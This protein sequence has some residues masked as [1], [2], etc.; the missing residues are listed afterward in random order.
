MRAAASA[1]LILVAAC[2]APPPPGSSRIGPDSS[3]HD[4]SV[5]ANGIA[6]SWTEGRFPNKT[7]F[8]VRLDADGPERRARFPNLSLSGP[9][10]LA[11]DGKTA[12]AGAAAIASSL[13]PRANPVPDTLLWIQAETGRLL[14]KRTL[15]ADS[16]LL[17]VHGPRWAPGPLALWRTGRTVGWASFSASTPLLGQSSGRFDPAVPA[18]VR[19]DAPLAAL[20]ALGRP[21]LVVLDLRA[22]TELRRFPVDLKARPLAWTDDGRLL[23]SGWSIAENAYRLELLD[24]RDGSRRPLASLQGEAESAAVRGTNALVIALD[25]DRRA[26]S[27]RN[28]M[29]SRRLIS[30]DL[31]AERLVWSENWTSRPGRLLGFDPDGRVLFEVTDSDQPALW[32]LPAERAALAAAV[33]ALDGSKAVGS[34]FLVLLSQWFL[35]LA[36]VAGAGIAIYIFRR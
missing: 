31:R 27:G 19:D 23:A 36:G 10:A 1:L 8:T 12:L 11:A 2:Q 4:F 14:E 17:S 24:P 21:A 29:A 3:L 16:T 13:S 33:P 5:G 26:P 18:V 22:G 32:A 6:T 15:P 34:R 30:L 20:A 9:S 35:G 25:P 7:I 28:W